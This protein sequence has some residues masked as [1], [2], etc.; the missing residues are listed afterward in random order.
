MDVTGLSTERTEAWHAFMQ[1]Q[2]VLTA[3]MEQQLQRN[4][5]LSN[6][7]YSILAVLSD[8]PGCRARVFEVGRL[9]GWEKSRLHHQLTRMEHR[10][11]VR[12]EA[13]PDSPRAMHAVL[14]DAGLAAIT[15]AAPAHSDNV[16]RLFFDQ[17]T[18]RQ[19]SQ[20]T[21]I[22]HRVL[23]QLLADGG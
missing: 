3:R 9:L 7:D 22:S 21:D 18:D 14:T 4:A 15:A 1:M 13:D 12:R 11:L 8:M 17:L 10:G 23:D 16:A 5:N 2:E 20:L 6:A 19:V